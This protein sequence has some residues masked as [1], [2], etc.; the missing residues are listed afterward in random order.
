M[1]D[2]PPRPADE[3]AAI[4]VGALL[5]YA[6]VLPLFLLVTVPVLWRR[7]APLLAIAA[8]FAGLLLN[9]ALVGTEVIRCGVVLPTAFLLAF[10]AGSYLGGPRSDDRLC[11][12]RW[13]SCV[14]DGASSSGPTPSGWCS[15]AYHGRVLGHRPH[16][17]LPRSD[18]RR[19]GGA[20]ARA[21]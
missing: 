21:A 5:P 19:A 2:P 1:A 16:R 18:G 3:Q 14:V 8:A 13:D 7:V 12:R 11:A 4:H 9:I 20:H 10:A 6:F 17:A 15:L